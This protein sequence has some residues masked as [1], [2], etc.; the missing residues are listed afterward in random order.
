MY[1][2]NYR[3]QKTR[4]DKYLKAPVLEPR[5]IDDMGNG[6]KHWFNLNER[7]FIILIDHCEGN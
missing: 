2:R 1:Y 7:A 3:P 4:L 6:P 5:S